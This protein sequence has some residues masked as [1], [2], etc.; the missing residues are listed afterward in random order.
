[1]QW[2]GELTANIQ[3]QAWRFEDVSYPPDG[4]EG[5]ALQTDPRGNDQVMLLQDQGRLQRSPSNR[6][7]GKT[8]DPLG[9]LELTTDP[10]ILAPEIDMETLGAP[11]S[12][13]APRGQLPLPDLETIH[14]QS[15]EV[16]D[17]RGDLRPAWH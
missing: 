1:M 8:E 7:L 3:R 11:D 12:A 4:S 16:L 14:R 2:E 13:F 10:Y 9:D 17:P 6:F 15:K 5:T